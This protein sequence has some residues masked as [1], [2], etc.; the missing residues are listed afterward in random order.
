MEI[1]NV[2]NIVIVVLF[3][4]LSWIFK[5]TLNA[6]REKAKTDKAE[7]KAE[8][9]DVCRKYEK[10]EAKFHEFENEKYN[11]IMEVLSGIKA[12]I[13]VIKNEIDNIKGK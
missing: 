9:E 2:G 3:G 12:D 13:A 6:I 1:L 4:V 8:V 11:K 10:L 7:L 5:D